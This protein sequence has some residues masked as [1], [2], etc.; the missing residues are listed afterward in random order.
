MKKL[1]ILAIFLLFCGCTDPQHAT[2]ILSDQGYKDIRITG[3]SF[4]ACS[5]HDFYHTGFQAKS[6]TG[7]PVS[8]TVC[9]GLIF[10]NS[11]IR[12]E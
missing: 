12:F 8:G 5:E 4:F 3:Y 6:P 11:T 2:K 7:T 1:M 10:K 9:A